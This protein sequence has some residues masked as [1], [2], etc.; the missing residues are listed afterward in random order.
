MG[1]SEDSSSISRKPPGRELNGFWCRRE[2]KGLWGLVPL[3]IRGGKVY[4]TL[5][6]VKP[7]QGVRNDLLIN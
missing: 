3:R 4:G 5:K 6:T 1:A 7:G 2:G